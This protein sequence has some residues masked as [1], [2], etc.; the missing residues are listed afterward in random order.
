[1]FCDFT[2]SF[3]IKSGFLRRYTEESSVLV[4]IN[5]VKNIKN[6]KDDASHLQQYIEKRTILY[7]T[8]NKSLKIESILGESVLI[9]ASLLSVTSPPSL[10]AIEQGSNLIQNI[11]NTNIGNSNDSFFSYLVITLAII[12]T[13]IGIMNFKKNQKQIKAISALTR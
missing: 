12:I 1:M 2:T 8:L 5:I 9:V 11:D 4:L 10:E 6:T 13:I 3:S 7:N